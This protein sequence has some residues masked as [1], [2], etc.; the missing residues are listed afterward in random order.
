[1]TAVQTST[2]LER[3]EAMREFDSTPIIQST[4]RFHPEL[5]ENDIRERLDA[6]LQWFAVIPDAEEGRALQMIESVD[7]VWHAFIL[8]TGLYKD[9]CNRFVGIFVD[10]DPI[11]AVNQEVPRREYAEYTYTLL[12]QAFGDRLNKRFADLRELLTCCYFKPAGCSRSG[13]KQKAANM[14]HSLN[15]LKG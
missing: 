1:M 15:A 8:N 13:A 5:T 3:Y 4:E 11:E 7:V 2:A 12:T 6:L 14:R 9:F 10:H